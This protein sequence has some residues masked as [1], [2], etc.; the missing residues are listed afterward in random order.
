[1]ERSLMRKEI[2]EFARRNPGFR[3][4][5]DTVR[6]EDAKKTIPAGTQMVVLLDDTGL[7]RGHFRGNFI[8]V[9]AAQEWLDGWLTSSD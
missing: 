4:V 5:G 8:S 6:P 9:E 3:I 2:D 7:P 1:M